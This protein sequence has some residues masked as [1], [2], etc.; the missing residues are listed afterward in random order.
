MR[1]AD[2]VSAALLLVL[3]AVVA[4]GTLDLPYWS[5]FAPGPAFAARWV[6]LVA[7][8]LAAVLLWEALT[9][10]EHAAI[11]WPDREGMRRVVLACVLLWAFLAA[12]PW[13]GFTVD[14][15]LLMLAMLLGVQRRRPI[16]SLVATAITVAGAWGLFIAWL[17]IKL[18]AGPWGI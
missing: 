1:R 2:I 17:Q 16:P 14:A 4:G 3:A 6:A 13:L 7:S 9:R 11:E 15:A 12:L 10:R 5:E 18:P 8:I